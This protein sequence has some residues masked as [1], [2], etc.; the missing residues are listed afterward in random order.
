MEEK[1]TEANS[2]AR[3]ITAA[4]AEVAKP[5]LSPQGAVDAVLRIAHEQCHVDP[6]HAE[7][8]AGYVNEFRDAAVAA[9]KGFHYADLEKAI[10]H[11][12][13]EMRYSGLQV[14]PIPEEPNGYPQSEKNSC[15]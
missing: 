4:R 6:A 5:G 11:F 3:A 10:T 2:F 7:R 9:L 1:R 14:A 13:H 8:A 15:R 12:Y